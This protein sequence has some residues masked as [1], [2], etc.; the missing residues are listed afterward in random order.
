MTKTSEIQEEQRTLGLAS[1]KY[2]SVTENIGYVE[3]KESDWGKISKFLRQTFESISLNPLLVI[4][5]FGKNEL[6]VVFEWTCLD[7]L[8]KLDKFPFINYRELSRT[9]KF[10]EN[11]ADKIITQSYRVAYILLKK[12]SLQ[13]KRI[14]D[15]VASL[16][17]KPLIVADIENPKNYTNLIAL[18]MKWS[19]VSYMDKTILLLTEL[20]EVKE[21][22]CILGAW[23]E[24]FKSKSRT[25]SLIKEI[26][27]RYGLFEA[28]DY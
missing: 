24:W 23:H 7:D 5:I 10:D 17:A 20:L 9:F 25:K 6:W 2:S 22:E 12:E 19:A 11:V 8:E 26:E 14:I 21:Y 16:N 28:A 4:K 27:S 15:A 1:L 3:S 13:I 18:S